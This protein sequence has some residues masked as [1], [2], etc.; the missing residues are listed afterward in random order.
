MFEYIEFNEQ[1][2]ALF[3]VPS[4]CRRFHWVEDL[5]DPNRPGIIVVMGHLCVSHYCRSDQKN[6]IDDN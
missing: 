1:G 4:V 6:K 2:F 3:A 5:I